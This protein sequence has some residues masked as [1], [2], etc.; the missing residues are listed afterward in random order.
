MKE[1]K[2]TSNYVTIYNKYKILSSYPFKST[3]Y[4]PP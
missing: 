3:V 1:K 4:L 2:R